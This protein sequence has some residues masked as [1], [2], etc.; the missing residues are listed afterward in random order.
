MKPCMWRPYANPK[1]KKEHPDERPDVRGLCR[2]N[3][4]ECGVFA[5]RDHNA[6]VNIRYNLHCRT[7]QSEIRITKGTM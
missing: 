6:A 2:C 1:K 4:G 3:N 7:S 5:N